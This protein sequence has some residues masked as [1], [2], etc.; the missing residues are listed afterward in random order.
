MIEISITLK[1][2]SKYD[3]SKKALLHYFC[4]LPQGLSWI[5]HIIF[6]LL[7]SKMFNT[8]IRGSSDFVIL[9]WDNSCPLLLHFWITGGKQFHLFL[10]TWL[11]LVCVSRITIRYTTPMWHFLNLQIFHTKINGINVTCNS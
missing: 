9:S 3:C 7:I 11:W 2:K 4:L 1:Q 5:S 6:L 10:K 8:Y